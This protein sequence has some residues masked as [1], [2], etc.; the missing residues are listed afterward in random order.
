MSGY[1]IY[2]NGA[3]TS[4]MR[5]SNAIYRNKR[6]QRFLV[7]GFVPDGFLYSSPE[8]YKM[9]MTDFFPKLLRNHVYLRYYRD[10]VLMRRRIM[11]IK[12]HQIISDDT[13]LAKRFY[14]GYA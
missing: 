6:I 12:V 3:Y 13:S 8:A 4:D 2:N 1:D 7:G 14:K 9:W 10:R 5:G 11:L